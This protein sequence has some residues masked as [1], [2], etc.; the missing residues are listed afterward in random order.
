MSNVKKVKLKILESFVDKY[1]SDKYKKD[2]IIEVNKTRG[3]EL[4]KDVRHL[5]EEIEVK[6][7][8]NGD[9]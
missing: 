6:E 5:V 1:T 8:N 4:L 7:N 3:N 9:E 2:D